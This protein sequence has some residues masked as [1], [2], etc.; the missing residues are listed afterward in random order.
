MV[1]RMLEHQRLEMRQVP[2]DR[3]SA[4]CLSFMSRQ[5][6]LADYIPQANQ[7]VVFD[8]FWDDR[9]KL[10]GLLTPIRARPWLVRPAPSMRT[11]QRPQ[12]RFN[13]ITWAQY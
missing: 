6:G 2:I 3:P 13:P 4:L 8:E 5:F 1:D 12:Q 7:F 10:R 11:P 9:L